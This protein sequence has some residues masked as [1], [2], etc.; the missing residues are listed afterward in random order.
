MLAAHQHRLL[1]PAEPYI[2]RIKNQYIIE[3][4]CKMEK[5][6]SLLKQTKETIMQ[7]RDYLRATEGNHALQVEVDVDPF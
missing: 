7:E 1:G 6:Q 5:N 3:L 4:L 2:N